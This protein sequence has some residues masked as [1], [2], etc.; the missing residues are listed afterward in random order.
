VLSERKKR[1]R[2]FQKFISARARAQ[3]TYM[4]SERAFK[5][6]LRLEHTERPPQLIIEV[7]ISDSLGPYI[8]L[9]FI[10]F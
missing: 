7:G 6:R 5:G 3:F 8:S 9:T 2:L 10:V 1:W 4:M